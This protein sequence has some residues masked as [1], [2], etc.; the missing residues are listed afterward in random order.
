[1]TEWTRD[2][3]VAVD[4][5]PA[6]ALERTRRVVPFFEFRRPVDLEIAPDG[7]LYVLEYGSGFGG[8][9]DDAQLVRIEYSETGDLTPVAVASASRTAGLAPLA[10]R[11]SAA[12]SRAPGAGGAITA[13]EWDLDGDGLPDRFTPE[14]DHTF[15]ADGVNPVSLVVTDAAGRRS[16]PDVVEVAVGNEPPVVT[17]ES[18]AEGMTVANGQRVTVRGRA[19]DHEDGAGACDRLTW[20]VFLGHNAHSHPQLFFMGCEAEFIARVP[21]DHGAAADLFLVVELTYED[22]GG[23]NGTPPLVGSATVRLNVD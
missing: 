16:F 23:A 22:D 5:D 10:V 20:Q 8:D 19:E 14:V 15:A 9:N 1:M 12:G 7:A 4:A 3:I 13:Y 21:A 2:L 18:P 11:L 17:I 6:G